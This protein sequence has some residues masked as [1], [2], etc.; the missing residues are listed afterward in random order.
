MS[1]FD[2]FWNNSTYYVPLKAASAHLAAVQLYLCTT[3]N[4]RFVS[5]ERKGNAIGNMRYLIR[6]L[7]GV[8]RMG[9]SGWT[10]TFEFVADTVTGKSLCG[11]PDDRVG[12]GWSQHLSIVSNVHFPD[13]SQMW[14][15]Q[16]NTYYPLG[17]RPSL[18]CR[19]AYCY[20]SLQIGIQVAGRTF[21]DYQRPM[22]M[23]NLNGCK[24][25][26]I[27]SLFSHCSLYFSFSYLFIF[28]IFTSSSYVEC[29]Q[30]RY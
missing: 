14:P 8:H 7:H 19:I 10:W 22:T 12:T 28:L 26:V 9:E 1:G 3:R 23:M 16:K 24:I 2:A 17:K 30:T 20:Y 18:T 27:H 4:R 15:L 13:D 25:R 29:L 5:L 6:P 11:L 21:G